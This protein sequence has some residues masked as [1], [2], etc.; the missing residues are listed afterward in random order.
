M[1]ELWETARDRSPVRRALAMLGAAVPEAEAGRI[2]ALPIGARDRLLLQLRS[3]CF[4]RRLECLSTCPDCAEAV[5][6]ELTLDDLLAA[7]GEAPAAEGSV[8]WKGRSVR[9]RPVTSAD[10]LALEHTRPEEMILVL[11]RTCVLDADVA[12]PIE[13]AS[14]VLA[15]LDPGADLRFAIICPACGT[16][17]SSV[18]DIGAYLWREVEMVARRLLPE[19]HAIAAAYGWSETA[20]LALSSARRQSYLALIGAR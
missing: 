3:A 18:F 4:G 12:L 2:A 13:T 7:S 1:L 8:N 16:R 17:W 9:L 19:V 15:E 6:F 20:I 10:L 14:A 5:E 11:S